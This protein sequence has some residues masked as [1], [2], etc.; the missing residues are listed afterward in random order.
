MVKILIFILVSCRH[1][2]FS[3]LELCRWP[4]VIG[5]IVEFGFTNQQLS[6]A[7]KSGTRYFLPCEESGCFAQKS[8]VTLVTTSILPELEHISR[9]ILFA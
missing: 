3:A 1:G 5:H 7:V 9:E 6:V 4:G 8:H 2:M